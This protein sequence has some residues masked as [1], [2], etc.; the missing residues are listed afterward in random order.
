MGHQKIAVKQSRSPKN[1]E[2]DFS[3]TKNEGK[4]AISESLS[5]FEVD[6]RLYSEVTRYSYKNI[7]DIWRVH[8]IDQTLK[9]GDHVLQTFILRLS[10]FH[11]TRSSR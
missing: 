7:K 3:Y 11:P 10:D 5:R 2:G 8:R 4:L 6:G 1:I 9:Q